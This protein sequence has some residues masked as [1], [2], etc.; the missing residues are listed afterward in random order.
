MERY[1]SVTVRTW[2]A[3]HAA[4]LFIQIL[5]LFAFTEGP[6]PTRTATLFDHIAGN[7]NTRGAS[8]D[9]SEVLNKIKVDLGDDESRFDD[10]T[11]TWAFLKDI[12]CRISGIGTAFRLVYSL[13]TLNYPFIDHIKV[14]A[15]EHGDSAGLVITWIIQVVVWAGIIGG[16]LF[17][18]R[19]G[20]MAIQSGL[21]GAIISS[22]IRNPLALG[23]VAVGAIVLPGL[24][25]LLLSILGC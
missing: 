25:G 13:F 15:A 6:L 10:E 9:S 16:M 17:V 22:A 2:V 5:Y 19:I 1:L 24:A 3:I 14:E 4:F 20:M 23:T 11:E 18:V 7:A 12:M 8:R 21:I